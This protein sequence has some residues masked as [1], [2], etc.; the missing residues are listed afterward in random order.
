MSA[1]LMLNLSE[2]FTHHAQQNHGL[3]DRQAR[4]GGSLEATRNVLLQLDCESL[5]GF[6]AIVWNIFCRKIIRNYKYHVLHF[7]G[8]R[9]AAELEWRKDGKRVVDLQKVET[10]FFL[11]IL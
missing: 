5:V 3:K 10:Q 4:N 7:K 9:P 2:C 11:M 6:S 8:G 1:I